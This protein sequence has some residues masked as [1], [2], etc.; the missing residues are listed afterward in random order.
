SANTDGVYDFLARIHQTSQ[1]A[2]HRADLEFLR[3]KAT[4]PRWKHAAMSHQVFHQARPRNPRYRP[5]R[6]RQSF[7]QILVGEIVLPTGIQKDALMLD[8]LLR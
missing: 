5:E 8:A 2:N 6:T 7:A 3:A 1:V 4:Q